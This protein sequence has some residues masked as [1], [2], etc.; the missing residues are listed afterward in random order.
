MNEWRI[1]GAM[2]LLLWQLESWTN[3]AFWIIGKLWE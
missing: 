2:G 1:L 3:A